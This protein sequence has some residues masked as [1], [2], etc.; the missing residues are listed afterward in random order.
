M[1]EIKA[2]STKKEMKE[3]T[4]ASLKKLEDI[5]DEVNSQIYDGYDDDFHNGRMHF[6]SSLTRAREDAKK[7]INHRKERY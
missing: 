2:V 3:L 6:L 1:K 4:M 7:V 5:I